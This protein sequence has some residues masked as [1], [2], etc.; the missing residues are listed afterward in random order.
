MLK[1]RIAGVMLGIGCTIGLADRVYE[2]SKIEGPSHHSEIFYLSVNSYDENGEK[3]DDRVGD[4]F[5]AGLCIGALMSV[6]PRKELLK[7][8]PSN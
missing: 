5:L 4:I 8:A 1:R 2:G 6:L 7:T 3:H